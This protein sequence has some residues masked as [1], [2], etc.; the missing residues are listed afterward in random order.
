MD[1]CQKNVECPHSETVPVA[2]F[3]RLRH[4]ADFTAVRQGVAVGEGGGRD[5]GVLMLGALLN[6]IL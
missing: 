1:Y 6:C 3:L 4:A 2:C 5:E